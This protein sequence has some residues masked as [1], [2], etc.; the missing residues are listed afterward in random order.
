[1]FTECAPMSID[2]LTDGHVNLCARGAHQ[3]LYGI[4]KESKHKIVKLVRNFNKS[5]IMKFISL[6][7]IE[8]G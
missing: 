3:P 7:L 5:S 6:V 8:I 1:M 4:S 2:D